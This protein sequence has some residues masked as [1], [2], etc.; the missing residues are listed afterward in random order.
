MQFHVPLKQYSDLIH[1]QYDQA[2]ACLRP[3]ELKPKL[4]RYLRSKLQLKKDDRLRY[5]VRVRPKGDCKTG[6]PQRGL[7]FGN[8]GGK[9]KKTV[10]YPKG[11]IL[12]VNTYFDQPLADATPQTLPLCLALENF[13]TRQNKGF[14]SFYT[15]DNEFPKIEEALKEAERPVF[16]FPCRDLKDA[17][18]GIDA[19]Y[20]AMKAGINESYRDNN[21]DAYL[22]SL[23]WRY[24]NDKKP[25]NEKITWEKR[26]MKQA[27]DGQII[28]DALYIR[29]LLGLADNFSFLHG[30]KIRKDPDYGDEGTVYIQKGTKFK[31]SHSDISRFK[32][33]ITFKPVDSRVYIILNPT[34]YQNNGQKIHGAAFTFQGP[35]GSYKLKVP[36]ADQFD[37]NAF[38]QFV[39]D[40]INKNDFG[41]FQGKSA[42]RL[43]QMKIFALT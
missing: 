4:D 43:K 38:M 30:G 19:L 39:M 27:V 40:T 35:R 12:S 34:A 32:S 11:A 23:L 17:Y 21:S 20:R 16:Y 8:I 18:S 36:E 29:A 3:T 14:G 41:N 1:F 31:V 22:K 9:E 10:F 5:Q 25:P 15:E 13:G 33:P 2:D 28:Q 42:N 6:Q 7:Y 24:F 26:F 37:L